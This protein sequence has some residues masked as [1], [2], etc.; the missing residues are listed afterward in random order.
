MRLGWSQ[1]ASLV[2]A[3]VFGTLRPAGSP[4]GRVTALK[5]PFEGGHKGR[6]FGPAFWARTAGS[7]PRT[8]RT[9][10]NDAARATR[11]GEFYQ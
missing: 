3:L 2:V 4:L 9:A 1:P 10:C 5:P 7:K 8:A 11:A 6:Q